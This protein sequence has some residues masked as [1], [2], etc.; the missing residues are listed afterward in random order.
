MTMG[1]GAALTEELA[2]DKRLG[3]FVNQD[4]AGYEVPGKQANYV[5]KPSTISR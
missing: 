3:L 1:V 2:V 4:L 5:S